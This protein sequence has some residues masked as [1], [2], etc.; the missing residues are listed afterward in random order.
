VR[1]IVVLEHLSLD[2][3]AAGPD[4]G[5]D[6]VRFDDE[7]VDY[8]GAI[9]ATTEAPLFGR[10]TFEMMAGYWP[11]AADSPE[12]TKHDIEH[13]NWINNATKFV[14]SRTLESATWGSSNN[15][16]IVRNVPD[17][18]QKIKQEPG[19][20]LL[21]IGSL[22]LSQSL[23]QHGLIDEFHLNINPVILGT[24]KPFYADITTTQDL[25][26]VDSRRFSSSVLALHYARAER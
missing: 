5:L 2:G 18:I 8:V 3:L 20:N 4:G 13:A 24:G 25:E 1:K 19:G 26:L 14:V 11:T 9:T 23:I 6:W 15:V 17:D 12:A 21:L 10:V 16:R 22:G 7:L